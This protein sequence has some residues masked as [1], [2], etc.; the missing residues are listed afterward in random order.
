MNGRSFLSAAWV[1]LCVAAL[2]CNSQRAGPATAREPIEIDARKT[3]SFLASDELEGRGIGTAGLDRAAQLIADDFARLGLQR[4]PGQ[5]D[6]FQR[7]EMTTT[8]QIGAKTSLSIGDRVFAVREDFSPLSFSAEGSFDGPVV[9]CGYGMK[10][11]SGGYDDYAGVD[12][13]DKI[14]L[15][16]RYEPHDEKGKSR[17][18]KDG[19]SAD[20]ALA[21]KA[22]TAT[23][24]GAVA[25]LLVTP[26]NFHAGDDALVPFSRTPLSA[27]DD[28][29][30]L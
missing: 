29:L 27:N 16:M 2:G 5:R 7:F 14:V 24:A 26:E 20:A 9:F 1:S 19:W 4:P 8:T 11:E 18:E 25:L 10:R 30:P 13:K 12:V 6:Y 22:K 23:E 28:G 15:A 17:F 21:A 3:L